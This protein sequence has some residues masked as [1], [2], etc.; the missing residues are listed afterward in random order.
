MYQSSVSLMR[1]FLT[2]VVL[3]GAG[4]LG[5]VVPA[6]ATTSATASATSSD[7]CSAAYY[8]NDARLGP[9]T[10]PTTGKVGFELIG[11]RR[12]GGMST[13]DFLAK[14]YDSTGNGGA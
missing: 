9:A 8:N 2:A 7:Q 6:A 11:Y 13:A 4:L 12:T 14:Y 10:L 3:V 1:R 5:S